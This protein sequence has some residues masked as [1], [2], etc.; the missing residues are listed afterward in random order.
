M[1]N[2]NAKTPPK[3]PY[4][5]SIIIILAILNSMIGSNINS[6]PINIYNTG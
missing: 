3:T 4:F 1:K 6:L 2:S 5:H